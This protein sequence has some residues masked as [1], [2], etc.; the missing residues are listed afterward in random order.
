M[1]QT[2]Q[3][4]GLRAL[5]AK[6]QPKV[7]VITCK[8]NPKLSISC[9]DL[10]KDTYLSGGSNVFWI[11]EIPFDLRDELPIVFPV[12]YDLSQALNGDANS[13]FY[14]KNS[15]ESDTGVGSTLLYG[16]SLNIRAAANVNQNRLFELVAR[17][18]PENIL[19]SGFHKNSHLWKKYCPEFSLVIISDFSQTTTTND[20]TSCVDW[21]KGLAKSSSVKNICIVSKNSRDH[22]DLSR[23][24]IYEQLT[25]FLG[26]KDL[27]LLFSEDLLPESI[28]SLVSNI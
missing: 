16:L 17:D 14:Y 9:V 20:L 6:D 24:N 3:A 25:S 5:F 22:E 21:A 4:S 23:Q 12:K 19:I 26:R 15:V 11:D 1:Q 8:E 2:D 27:N 10:L 13:D 28:T 18:K 7:T